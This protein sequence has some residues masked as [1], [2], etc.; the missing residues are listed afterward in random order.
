MKKLAVILLLAA[1]F[2]SYSQNTN[3]LLELTFHISGTL[4]AFKYENERFPCEGTYSI[5]VYN[6][7][8][9]V[10]VRIPAIPDTNS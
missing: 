6:I 4:N 2:T 8:I 3:K 9:A 5:T 10:G 7:N 1:S